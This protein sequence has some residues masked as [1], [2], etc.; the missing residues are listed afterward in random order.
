MNDDKECY[1]AFKHYG[2][3]IRFENLSPEMNMGDLFKQFR[4]LALAITFH[5]NTVAKYFEDEE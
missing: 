3:V 2:K 5:P 1:L 4:L